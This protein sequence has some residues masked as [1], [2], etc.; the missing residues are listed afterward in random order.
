MLDQMLPHADC[1]VAG[2]VA[3]RD[4]AAIPEAVANRALGS[5]GGAEVR[6]LAGRLAVRDREPPDAVYLNGIT[7]TGSELLAS[8]DPA[9]PVV[10]HV[11]EL[12][13]G[14]DRNTSPEGLALIRSRTDRFV[15]VS[16][17]VQEMVCRRFSLETAQVPVVAGLLPDPLPGG[18]SDPAL[19]DSGRSLMDVRPA[20]AFV[21]GACGVRD[22][23]KAPD[24]FV[25]MASEVLRSAPSEGVAFR[26]IGGS[27]GPNDWQWRH[28]VAALQLQSAMRFIEE[29]EDVVAHF[30][31]LDVLVVPAREDAYPLAALEAAA[32]GVPIVAFDAGGLPEFIQQDAGRVVAPLD[33]TAMAGA[34]NELLGDAELRASCGEVGS[35]RIRERH[36]PDESAHALWSLIRDVA[37]R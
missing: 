30:A 24:L 13:I 11:H 9:V 36:Q 23:R 5:P 35:R 6:R 34:V 32:M 15:A 18:P 2:T 33:T 20:E 10:T 8:V 3:G 22:W 12:D 37:G 1:V 31:G 16:K 4:L 17:A 21:V 27:D 29:T 14:L 28:D 19:R 7:Q 25:R 26:W